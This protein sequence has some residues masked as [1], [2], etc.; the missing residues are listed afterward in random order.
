MSRLAVVPISLV[1]VAAS[2]TTASAGVGSHARARDLVERAIDAPFADVGIEPISSSLAFWQA[3]VAERPED[4]L[5]RTR[6]ASTILAQARETGDLGLYPKAEAILRE[7]LAIN[8]TDEGALLA[9]AGARAAS[10]DF[11]GSM[12]LAEQVLRRNPT[13][14]GAKAAVADANFE[15][16]NYELAQQQLV[17]LAAELPES[18]AIDGR[19]AKLAA[20]H[21]H[22]QVAVRH[23]ARA[24]LDAAT[25]DLRP[26]EAAF[27]RFQLAY[28]LYQ[29]GE[30]RRALAALDA[31]LLID[32]D[33]LAS[34]EL[35]AK[36]LVSL[37][38]LPQATTLYE[39]LVNRT[40]AA[41][42]HG[43]L[44]KL[45]RALGRD[46]DAATQVARGLALGHDALLQFP[47]ER[48]HLAAF[49]AEFDPPAALE[50]AQADFGTRHDVGAY[51]ALAWAYYANGQRAA[52]TQYVDAALAQGTRNATLLYHA[53]MIK[54]AAGHPQAARR[55]LAAALR[56][57][58]HFDVAQAP[59]A[60]S[61][62]AALNQ[63]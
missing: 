63:A 45:Y 7:A 36:V 3:R 15:L 10:H 61:E 51:D 13:S 30:V 26:S 19:R 47:A 33:H 37:D 2:A 41:D 50:A 40:P 1:L 16:G 12:T 8:P 44:A 46:R 42:L 9:L 43:E 39:D 58:P 54:R 28:F 38:R 6:L 49:F 35:R 21:G 62:L 24:L 48:R 20:I 27:Y 18:A 34:L 52:A 32:P 57:D 56:L 5:S 25:L 11:A 22:N 53:G 59:I 55:M 29:G 4:Y 14:K 60:R 31:G 17:A 23:A